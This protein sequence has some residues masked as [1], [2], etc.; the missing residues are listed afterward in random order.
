MMPP[1]YVIR[2]PGDMKIDLKACEPT[3]NC[4][5]NCPARPSRPNPGDDPAKFKASDFPGP[6]FVPNENRVIVVEAEDLPLSGNWAFMSNKPNTTDGSTFTGRGWVRWT[7][8]GSCCADEDTDRAFQG[9]RCDW[10]V[11]KFFIPPGKEGYYQFEARGYNSTD[12]GD[13]DYW[14]GHIARTEPIHKAGHL[15]VNARKFNFG[16][17]IV[18]PPHR[19][20]AGLHAFFFMGRSVGFGFDRIVVFQLEDRSQRMASKDIKLP[21]SKPYPAGWFDDFLKKQAN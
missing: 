8:A 9:S 18:L 6:I 1:A 4:A 5:Q 7:G 15:P 14:M 11:V 20:Q 2:D 3:G 17:W 19:L 10:L 21:A 13:N 12:D 16:S